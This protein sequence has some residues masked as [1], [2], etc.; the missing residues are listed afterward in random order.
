MTGSTLQHEGQRFDSSDRPITYWRY[1]LVAL[2]LALAAVVGLYLDTAVAMVTI[3]YRSE[4]FTHAFV[5]PPIALWLMWRKRRELAPMVPRASPVVLIPMV[6]MALFWLAGEVTAINSVTQFAFVAMLVLTVPAILGLAVANHLLF[7]LCFMFFAVPVGE[8]LTPLFMIWTADFTVM[9]LRM[10]GIPVLREGLQFVIPS[11]NWSVVEAC[12]GTRY[13]IASVTVGALFA[14]LN[15]QSTKRRVTFVLVSVLVPIVANWLRA[16]MIVMLGHL[17]GN[18]LAVGVD[19][20]I[21]GWVFFGVVILAM[22]WIGSK[23]A[24]PE[25]KSGPM[26]ESI[27]F[28]ATSAQSS[29]A[30]LSVVLVGALA[31]AAGP[32]ASERLLVR[33]MRAEPVALGSA[34][35]PVAGW[36]GTDDEP[37]SFRPD[38]KNPSAE[39]QS[40]YVSGESSVG[41]FVAYYRN[42]TFTKKLISS[43][44]VLA[45]SN[46]DD[47]NQLSTGVRSVALGERPGKVRTAVLR[48]LSATPP[49]RDTRL[50]AWQIY[51]I[52]GN[53]TSND[54]AAKA[55]SAV[56]QILGR[57]DESAVIVVYT[58]GGSEGA[59]T[60]ALEKFLRE[61]YGALDNF[62]QQT[63]DA[64]SG[65]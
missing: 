21:Y 9:A 62:L 48:R 58:L 49:G 47:W 12:S 34:F 36:Q 20:L 15:Y 25:P 31:I 10:S 18:T 16:Y 45:S 26:P 24:E 50:T 11:G 38:F 51:W 22:F 7:P 32:V 42:Q 55:Y 53:L 19:H 60:P 35:R 17:S 8:F 63:R 41:L 3:W 40:T 13:L 14:H 37:F 56:N 1:P 46:S 54:Y 59:A 23:W 65:R 33:N 29:P 2:V 27:Q 43:T 28:L 52:D 39:M 5:V 64:V 30:L 44:N 57:G 4:T 61:N 6:L